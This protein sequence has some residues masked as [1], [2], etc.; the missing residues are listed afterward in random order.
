[1]KKKILHILYSLK[2]GGAENVAFN[3]AQT[4]NKL[5]SSS[6]FYGKSC[7]LEYKRKL[8][9]EHIG[10]INKFNLSILKNFDFI[11]IHCNQALLW[12]LP[13]IYW[14]RKKQIRII[15]VQHNYYSEK[16]FKQVSK[17]VNLMCTDFIRIT[18]KTE[19]LVDKYIR[20]KK[21]V[22]INYYINK[23]SPKDYPAIRKEVRI[24]LNLSEDK[25]VVMF[26]SVFRNGKGVEDFLKIAEFFANDERFIFL[27]VGDGPL[28]YL[29]EN[30]SHRN[31]IWVGFQT[32]VE[33]FLISSDV[34][35]FTSKH[36][37]MPMSLIEAINC[38]LPILAYDVDVVNFCMAK[39]NCRTLDDMI[40]SLNNNKI[41]QG[42]KHR[43]ID[44]AI[45]KWLD[46]LANK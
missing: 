11:V 1:M 33:R 17:L 23:Y 44:Y 32:D 19:V 41:P 45:N 37:M 16:K 28:R 39:K 35:V 4:M 13:F 38:D 8:E 27:I 22:L 36:E 43:D 3:Y 46:I 30:Y 9:A 24:K 42:F 15:Y 2:N 26:S 14:I 5:G 18:P 12:L 10:Y 29:V 6:V 20:I 40:A 31:V 25:R 34:Y 7:T 21:K